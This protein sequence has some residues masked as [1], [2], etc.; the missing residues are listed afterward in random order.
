MD[1]QATIIMADTYS[2]RGM[3]R[4][5]G[6][7][8]GEGGGDGGGGRETGEGGGERVSSSIKKAS[9]DASALVRRL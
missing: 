9:A 7:E 6:G 5:M 3:R 2:E 8:G 1:R 4:R